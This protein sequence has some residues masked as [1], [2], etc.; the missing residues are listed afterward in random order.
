MN[1][2]NISHNTCKMLFLL[3]FVLSIDTPAVAHEDGPDEQSLSD[4]P[5]FL[6]LPFIDSAVYITQGWIYD[7]GS[8]HY[9]IDYAK[10]LGGVFQTFDIVAAADGNATCYLQGTHPVLSWHYGNLIQIDHTGAGGGYSTI[11]GHLPNCEFTSRTIQR[12]ERIGSAGT[13]GNSTGIHLHFEIRDSSFI[14]RDPY[15]IHGYDY[16]YPQPGQSGPPFAGANHYWTTNP[17]SYPSY[18]VPSAPANQNLVGNP[19][20]SA[21]HSQWTFAVPGEVAYEV[22]NGI[23]YLIRNTNSPNYAAAYQ[24]LNYSLSANSPIELSLD[25]GNTSNVVKQVK[26][27][28]QPMSWTGAFQ[29]DFTLLPHTPLRR[30]VMRGLATVPFPNTRLAIY[31]NPAD[32]TPDIMVDNVSLQY[33]PDIGI[34]ATECIAPADAN[35]NLVRN[36]NFSAGHSQWTFVVPGEVAYEVRNGILYLIRNTN[37]PNYAAAYQDLNYSL[38]ANSPIELTLDLGNT[39]NVV[40][41]VKV[42]VQPMSWTGAFQCDFTLLPHTPLRRYVIRGLATVPFPNTR[43][44]IYPNPADSTPDIMVD[45]ISLQYRP[46]IGVGATECIAPADANRNLVRNGNF[47]AGHSQ[48]TFV[49]PGE[50]AYE[51]RNGILYLIRN[52]NSPNYAAAYQDLN[53]SLNA[54]SPIDLSLDLGNTSNV[55][56]QVKVAVQPMS[57][58]GAFQCDFTLLPHTPLRRYVMRGL[59]TIP[60]PNTRLAIYPNPADS[61]PDIMV[62]NI[63]LQYRPDIGIGATECIAPADA[64][65]FLYLPF[66]IN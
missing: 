54:N 51:V 5:K 20:F 58:T 38:N 11:Y 57:W 40:K 2:L 21:G 56:K 26:V 59:A 16:S 18:L 34:G 39:S 45:N 32:S 37:S 62:D 23:L 55:V 30:Y 61:T 60:F 33:R 31:P 66:V 15:Y 25:L 24:D 1:M 28:V 46:D 44:A 12:G 50:V 29:C 43:L 53:Y 35:Q 49:V 10:D 19:N 6:T 65:Q 4:T 27:A 13:T 3:I 14:A 47:S 63:S 48:W 7:W 41:Q 22:R 52:T 64:N 42:A 36:G 17:P 9:G 8:I